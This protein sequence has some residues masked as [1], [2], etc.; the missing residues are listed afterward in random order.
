MNLSF[1]QAG[2]LVHTRGAAK[3]VRFGV[4]CRAA[5]LQGVDKLADAVQVTMGPKVRHRS[6]LFVICSLTQRFL[7]GR[8]ETLHALLSVTASWIPIM[9]L[10]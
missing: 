5:V 1:P 3:D 4:D 6:L 10:P 2:A 9:H 8:E 7:L